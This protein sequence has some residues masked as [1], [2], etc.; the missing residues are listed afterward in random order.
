MPKFVATIIFS[1][2]TIASSTAFG[3]DNA[4][5]LEAYHAAS[6]LGY[7]PLPGDLEAIAA[8]GPVSWA[9]NIANGLMASDDEALSIATRARPALKMGA[10]ELLENP[11]AMGQYLVEHG[12]MTVI[13]RTSSKNQIM[14]RMVPFW[15]EVFN[16]PTSTQTERALAASFERE[17]ARKFWNAP[18]FSIFSRAV[19]HP[20]M[21]RSEDPLIDG[22]ESEAATGIKAKR[23]ARAAFGPENAVADSDIK[24]LAAVFSGWRPARAK[25]ESLRG[26]IFDPGMHRLAPKTVFGIPLLGMKGQAEGE[27]AIQIMSIHPL[28]AERFAKAFAR[29]F[30][31]DAPPPSI[32]F[33]LTKT[34]ISSSGN[35]RKMIDAVVSHADFWSLENRFSKLRPPFEAAIAAIRA[36]GVVPLWPRDA[37]AASDGSF[38]YPSFA[39]KFCSKGA[40]LVMDGDK[41]ARASESNVKMALSPIFTREEREAI[42]SSSS[43]ACSMLAN[44]AFYSQ[45]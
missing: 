3:E 34:F 14:E 33:D 35:T 27:A 22:K 45:R 30:V 44:K 5:L 37:T 20:A 39:A 31:A 7:G 42:A 36:A 21:L 40:V 23:I 8:V 18:F 4:K 10:K 26:F 25:E 41:T 2:L 17:I 28:V 29:H 11:Q 16:P 38:D 1:I 24:A 32:V 15:M 9:K 43:P 12:E 13:E 19:R 6:R